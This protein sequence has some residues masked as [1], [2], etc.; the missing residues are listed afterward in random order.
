MGTYMGLSYACHFV[1]YVE[2]FLF[3]SYTGTIPHLFLC[4][5][6]DCI[7]TASCFQEEL[8]Q[9]IHFTNTFSPTLK[10]T[11]TISDTSLPFLDLSDEAFHSWTSQMS[12]YFKDRN[13][14]SH[15]IHKAVN[16]ISCISC[17]SALKSPPLNNNKDRV[18]LVLADS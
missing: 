1:G 5:I 10:F 12:S 7:G 13:F 14:P 4:C 15:M 6:D 18:S 11:W 9:F 17:T 16:R 2:Q 3:F 8:K